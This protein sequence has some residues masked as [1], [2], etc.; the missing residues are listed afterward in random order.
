MSFTAKVAKGAKDENDL[1]GSIL[2]AAFRVHSYK[3][4]G[5]WLVIFPAATAKIAKAAKEEEEKKN[6]PQGSW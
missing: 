2:D 4:I 3:A 1:S 5:E 6:G